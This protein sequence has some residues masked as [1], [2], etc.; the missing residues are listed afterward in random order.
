MGAEDVCPEK[1]PLT[2][3]LTEEDGWTCSIC[4]AEL[5]EG[6]TLFGCRQCEWDCCADCLALCRSSTSAEQEENQSLENNATTS[7]SS[8]SETSA[9]SEPEQPPPSSSP[10]EASPS[11]PPPAVEMPKRPLSAYFLFLK[12]KRHTITGG[13]TAAD[14]TKKLGAMWKEMSET[15]KAHY[16]EQAK[17]AKQEYLDTLKRLGLASPSK[18]RQAKASTSQLET[19]QQGPVLPKRPLSGYFLFR[20]DKLNEGLESKKEDGSKG[21]AADTSKVIAQLWKALTEEE[22]AVYT[23]QA[24]LAKDKYDQEVA[25]IRAAAPASEKSA[26]RSKKRRLDLADLPSY[27]THT[28]NVLP[29]G[30]VKRVMNI[31]ENTNLRS[32]NESAVVLLK[33]TEFFVHL[34]AQ[35]AFKTARTNKRNTVKAA[36]FY[37]MLKESDTFEFLRRP[38]PVPEDIQEMFDS[39]EEKKNAAAENK[40][41]KQA[42]ATEARQAKKNA[43]NR[44]LVNMFGNSDS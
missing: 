28:D 44:S 1:H 22:K 6:S 16:T 37:E 10:R 8:S 23:D 11:T 12:D 7:M 29:L 14:V 33:T 4:D 40:R 26:D 34:L 36:D 21:T 32:T 9:P 3:F 18:K 13:G 30:T 25:A 35:S 17:Q 38:M 19:E 41:M 24:K 15:D 43:N 20:R 31:A 2:E 27:P 5:A 42:A 39:V